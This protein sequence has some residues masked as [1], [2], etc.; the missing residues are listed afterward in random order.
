MNLPTKVDLKTNGKLDFETPQYGEIEYF[1][2]IECTLQ[3]SIQGDTCVID[4]YCENDT[5]LDDEKVMQVVK[6]F[7]TCG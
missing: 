3:I 1:E 7:N 4:Y 6:K 5:Y 2:N